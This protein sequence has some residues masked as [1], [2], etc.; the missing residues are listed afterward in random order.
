[1]ESGLFTLL[2]WRDP[3]WRKR[4]FYLW[5]PPAVLG[6]Y[7][8][9]TITASEATLGKMLR[10]FGIRAL[11]YY[12]VDSKLSPM[13]LVLTILTYSVML[14]PLVYWFSSDFSSTSCSPV[15]LRLYILL[16]LLYDWSYIL[17]SSGDKGVAGVHNSPSDVIPC[18][19]RFSWD[20]KWFTRVTREVNPPKPTSSSSTRF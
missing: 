2:T 9:L 5:F 6:F 20:W 1:M 12:P 14:W 17:Q 11:N 7:I 15:I 10:L 3:G 19:L 18:R 4:L 13:F 8:Y 16:I